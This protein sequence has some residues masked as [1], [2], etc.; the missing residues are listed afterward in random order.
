MLS[1]ILMSPVQ[2]LASF[3]TST[4]CLLMALVAASPAI[5]TVMTVRMTNPTAWRLIG[6][7]LMVA[8]VEP[9]LSTLFLER[10]LVPATIGVAVPLTVLEVQPFT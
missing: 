9:Q 2:T 6:L 10:V 5:T 8:V 4:Q 3:Q 1:L 7:K